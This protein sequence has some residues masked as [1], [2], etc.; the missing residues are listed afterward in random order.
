MS[1]VMHR[2]NI[3]GGGGVVGRRGEGDSGGNKSIR[4]LRVSFVQF[5]LRFFRVESWVRFKQEGI[6]PKVD[7]PSETLY[8]AVS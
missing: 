5:F 7:G 2:D 8:K 3:G 1:D 4:D 6:P